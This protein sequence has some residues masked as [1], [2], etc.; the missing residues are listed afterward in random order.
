MTDDTTNTNRSRC[1][2][3]SKANRSKTAESTGPW[4]PGP[5]PWSDRAD[6][7]TVDLNDMQP[8]SL[9]ILFGF[10]HGNERTRCKK[11]LLP[12][13]T[14][15]WIP[16][17]KGVPLTLRRFSRLWSIWF[18][19]ASLLHSVLSRT[20]RRHRLKGHGPNE[21]GRFLEVLC[22]SEPS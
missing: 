18:S 20:T 10:R 21:Q 2:A 22:S 11:W 16:S 3:L 19:C 1:I 14:I 9:K 5:G 6:V 7:L 15:F 13:L 17:E 12:L 4:A 8:H